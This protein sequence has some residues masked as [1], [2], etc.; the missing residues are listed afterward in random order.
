MLFKRA[1]GGVAEG[2]RA[3][4]AEYRALA[5]VPGM[6]PPDVATLERAAATLERQAGLAG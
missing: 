5:S 6:P 2:L 1:S 4:A 3:K